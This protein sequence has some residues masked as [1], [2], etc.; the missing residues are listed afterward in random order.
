VNLDGYRRGILLF[1]SGAF[2]DAHEVWEDVW[3]EA[4]GLKKKFL[5]GLIQVAVAFHHYSN[6]N[7]AGARSLLERGCK[8]LAECPEELAGISVTA[9]LVDL[10]T[11]QRC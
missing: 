1:N 8:N 2:F 6:G 4:D 5:Q 9:L 10:A 7:V 11:W 3:R